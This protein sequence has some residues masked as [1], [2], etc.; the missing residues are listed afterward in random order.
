MVT[1][2]KKP[3]CSHHYNIVIDLGPGDKVCKYKFIYPKMSRVQILLWI[4]K[5]ESGIMTLV[6]PA[7]EMRTMGNYLTYFLNWNDLFFYLFSHISCSF[8][9]TNVGCT[10]KVE[11]LMGLALKS[12]LYLAAPIWRRPSGFPSWNPFDLCL[13]AMISSKDLHLISSLILQFGSFKSSQSHQ[14]DHHESSSKNRNQVFCRILF[15]LACYCSDHGEGKEERIGKRIMVL[16]NVEFVFYT[17][18]L[19]LEL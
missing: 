13:L 2:T 14:F 15:L 4:N 3:Y 18:E 9:A 10:I 19:E 17:A 16:K 12:G 1:W 6:K 7:P 11:G 8:V 5:V